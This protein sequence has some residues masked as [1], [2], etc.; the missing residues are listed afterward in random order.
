[1]NGLDLFAFYVYYVI[2]TAF[3]LYFSFIDAASP[4]CFFVI[5]E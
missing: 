5:Y 2:P 4:H 1:M 3:F